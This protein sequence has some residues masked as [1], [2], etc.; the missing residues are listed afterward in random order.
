MVSILGLLVLDSLIDDTFLANI[1]CESTAKKLI[2][3]FLNL[4][5]LHSLYLSLFSNKAIDI[6]RFEKSLTVVT[7]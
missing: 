3:S 2:F 1:W 4:P 6:E 7:I 5:S